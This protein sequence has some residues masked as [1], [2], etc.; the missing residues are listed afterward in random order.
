V[1]LAADPIVR[2]FIAARE[3]V[4]REIFSASRRMEIESQSDDG[5]PQVVSYT[6]ST[7]GT[8]RTAWTFFIEDEAV[9]RFETG[10]AN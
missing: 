9:R 6:N 10:Q 3:W 7:W 4:D 5:R 2:A 1:V 8:M